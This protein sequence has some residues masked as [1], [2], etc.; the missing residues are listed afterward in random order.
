MPQ[1]SVFFFHQLSA[2]G[3]LVLIASH[4]VYQLRMALAGQELFVNP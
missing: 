3:H 2:S 1:A 4:S